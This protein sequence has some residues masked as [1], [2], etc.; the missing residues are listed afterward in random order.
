MTQKYIGIKLIEAWPEKRGDIREM[1][2][3]LLDG[4]AVKY[5][6]GYISWSP[7]EAFESAY[8]PIDPDYQ[9]TLDIKTD[10]CKVP[11]KQ[12]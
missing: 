6:D 9:V 4:Y 12:A 11:P 8:I 2:G 5:P 1:G 3:P 10:C 7:K